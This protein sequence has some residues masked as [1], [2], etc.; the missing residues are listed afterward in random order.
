MLYM[1]IKQKE[2]ER[3]KV[4]A[5]GGRGIEEYSTVQ[6][7]AVKCMPLIACHVISCHVI[8]LV[9]FVSGIAKYPNTPMI[10]DI[11]ANTIMP[12]GGA[13]GEYEQG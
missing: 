9:P 11:A 13:E 8:A 3:F 12:R 10:R 2:I 4:S 7:S 6:C 1:D 5:E